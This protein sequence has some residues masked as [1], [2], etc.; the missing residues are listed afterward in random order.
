MFLCVVQALAQ[1]GERNV[2][3]LPVVSDNFDKSDI[4]I[5]VAD[6]KPG[7]ASLYVS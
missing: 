7:W 5:K 6:S 1:C 3:K 4:V 2:D